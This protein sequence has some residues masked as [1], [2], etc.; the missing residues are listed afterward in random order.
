[1]IRERSW[2]YRQRATPR[3][4]SEFSTCS[5]ERGDTE[6][7]ISKVVFPILACLT[8][9]MAAFAQDT[10][11]LLRKD[12]S[13]GAARAA[14]EEGLIVPLLEVR[15]TVRETYDVVQF[16]NARLIADEDD[17]PL[18]YCVPIEVF[19]GT[20]LTLHVDPF[21]GEILPDQEQRSADDENPCVNSMEG[22][23]ART[24]G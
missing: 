1:M 17:A 3:S 16:Y 11:D 15:M 7:M 21:S 13:A 19:G 20:L 14:Q 5:A 12:L 18:V 2:V 22:A 4:P 9:A 8:C 10:A 23:D 24:G 6:Q